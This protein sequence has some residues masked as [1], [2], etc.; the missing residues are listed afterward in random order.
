ML[1]LVVVD[2]AWFVFSH[3]WV[4]FLVMVFGPSLVLLTSYAVFPKWQSWF[5]VLGRDDE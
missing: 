4:N 2:I 3:L 5:W 1:G